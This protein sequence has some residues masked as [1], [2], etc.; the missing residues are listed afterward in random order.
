MEPIRVALIDDHQLVRDGIKSLIHS[1]E[2]IKVVVE[3]PSP[4]LFFAEVEEALPEVVL[5]DISMPSMSGIE[6]TKIITEKYPTIKI[7]ILSMF[8]SEEFIQKAIGAGAKGYLPKNTSKQE[9]VEAITK[10]YQGEEFYGKEIAGI[11]LSNLVKKA[12]TE[13]TELPE[14]KLSKRELEILRLVAKG[15][16]NSHIAEML[17][18]SVKTV[19]AHKAHI[20]Q[21]MELSSH[22]DLIKVAIQLLSRT[23]STN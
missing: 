6:A 16:T 9:L 7:I 14:D 10:V 20:M 11:L 1:S 17:F 13:K 22:I 21:K 5:M 19:E 8:T 15:M 2:S 12:K 3:A 4:E 23:E 18:I